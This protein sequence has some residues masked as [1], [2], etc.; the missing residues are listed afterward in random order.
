MK[1]QQ[2]HRAHANVATVAGWV[3]FVLAAS[4]LLGW[5]FNLRG[6]QGFVSESAGIKANSAIAMMLAS[7]ALLRRNHRD[8]PFLSIAVF[9]IGA[10]TLSEYVWD[11]N[12]GIDEF[13][14]RD[15][16][17]FHYPGRM[18][19][20]TSIGYMLL[21]SSLLPMSSRHRVLRK[22]SRVLGILTGALGA[23]A[24]V[25]HGYDTHVMNLISPQNN[26]SIPTALG[27]VIG[28]I[29]VQYA[30]PSEGV[31]RLLHADNAGGAMLRRLL[32]TG[33][34]LTL[35]LGYAVRD[36]QLHYRWESGFALALVGLGV[37]AC[38]IAGIVLTAVDLE[39]QDLSRRESESLSILAAKAVPVM[40]WMSGT[41]KL[42]TYVNKPWLD[43]TGR[44]M[45]SELGSG[46]AEGIH[47][48]DLQRC[49][50]TFTQS[51]DRREEFRMEYRLRRYDGEYRWV[52]D[53]GVPRFDQD[54][55]LVGFIGIGVDV[56]D[57]KETERA[58]QQANRVLEEQ[59]AALQTREEL[60][61][62]FVTHVPAAVAMLDRDMR[63]LQVSDRFCADNSL[64]SSKI[65]GRLHY[66][67]FPD[68]PERWKETHRRGLAGETLRSEEDRWDRED[69]TT[70]LRWDIRP[71]QNLDGV[72]GGILIFSED[73]TRR[74]LAEEALS[75]MSR[76]LIEA[77]EQERTRI[78]RELHDD[79]VQQLVMLAVQLD[80]VRRDIPDSASELSKVIIDLRDQT[81][82]I[83][84]DVQS[85]SHE[86]HSSKLEYL[87]IVEAVKNFCKEFGEHQRVEIDFQSHD[88]PAALPTELSISLFRILQEALRNAMKHSGVER[89]EVKL[90]GCAEDVQLTVSDLGVGFDPQAAMKS[91]GLGLTSMQER[92]RLVG[93]ELSINSQ[94]K[95]GTTIRARVRFNSGGS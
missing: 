41:D 55:S 60:L 42:C 83:M 71:W 35:L 34:L 87:G 23:L 93:G 52:F 94:P 21:G 10:L 63:Y 30:T 33:V 5:A 62:T 95:C 47:P 58:L 19:Q 29:G 90:W 81:A 38:L 8:L 18:S 4:V 25:S 73:I 43:F 54:G 88:M 84:E 40:I 80:G 75:D 44:S 37:G 45:E 24:I 70:W 9:L 1:A 32:P 7:V 77:H 39:R 61:K 72:Q 82:D 3:L 22:L 56:T 50:D 53:F 20:Y 59:T 27:F 36:A 11:S 17:Y 28:A 76:K 57:R 78:G 26:V 6:L 49:L 64:D 13:L 89:F 66:E 74:K 15:T 85:L 12:F 65:L 46:W 51:F 92:L 16:N 2:D 68:L 69:G 91:T 67:V 31:V 48:E 14:F 86:L 79:I